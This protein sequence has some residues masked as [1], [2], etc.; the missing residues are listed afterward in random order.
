MN[1]KIIQDDF[2]HS[3]SSVGKFKN[4]P[5]AWL[6]HYGLGLRGPSSP[7]M[8]RGTLAEFGTYYKIK[9]GMNG[10]DGSAYAKIITHRFKKEKYLNAEQEIKN[11]IDISL[12]FEKILYER[13]LRDIVSYQRQEIKDVDGLK[14]PVRM[15]TDF[16]FKDL[17][18]IRIY[19]NKFTKKTINERTFFN[20]LSVSISPVEILDWLN[21]EA[22][23]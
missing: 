3:A 17:S 8:T 12:Q 9:K 19:C 21:N 6:C 13:Q 16:E 20:G 10:K 1:K 5:S 18:A 23:E 15:F 7:A 4:N 11:A 14:Y 2:K 22:Y